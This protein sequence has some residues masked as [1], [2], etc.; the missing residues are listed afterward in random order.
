M[1]RTAREKSSTGIYHVMQR[2]INRQVLFHDIEDYQKYLQTVNKYHGE[3]GYKIYAYCLMSNHIHLLIKEGTEDLGIAFRR[4]GASFVHWYNRKYSRCGHLFQDRYKS[5]AV[6]TD[7]YFLSVIRYIHNNP[8]Q[9]GMANDLAGY[10]WSS[11]EQYVGE[12]GI[13]DIDF[14]LGMFSTDRTEAIKLFKEFSLAEVQDRCLDCDQDV[15]L[16][17]AEAG[18]FIKRISGIHSPSEIALFEK[19][20]RYEVLKACRAKGL[21][22]RQ[23]ERLTGISIG[24]IRTI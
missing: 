23:I 9:A 3:S 4:I 13:C 17:D 2:G 1:P 19:D 10:R 18:A 7:S 22:L 6:E 11:Y 20:K 14:A 24:V 8:L 15:R 5:Q 12:A 16:N 21:S